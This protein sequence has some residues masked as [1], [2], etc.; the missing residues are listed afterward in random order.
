MKSILSNSSL[1]VQW[2]F[3]VSN[4]EAWHLLL[5]FNYHKFSYCLMFQKLFHVEESDTEGLL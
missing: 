4:N 3:P 2:V 1:S 5:L